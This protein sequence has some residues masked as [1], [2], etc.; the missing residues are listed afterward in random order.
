M[1]ENET[2][3]TTGFLAEAGTK[4]KNKGYFGS[5]EQAGLACWIVAER[6]DALE[7]KDSAKM[8]VEEIIGR[9][10]QTPTIAKVKIKE[11]LMA[12]HQKLK[13]ESKFEMLKASLVIVVTDYSQV[14]WA[15]AGN[16]RLYHFRE[17]KF[18]FRSK[19]QT[20]AQVMVDSGVLDEDEVNE[21][22]ERNNLIN[23]LGGITE[24]KPFVSEPFQLLDGDV[25]LLCNSGF[26]EKMKNNEIA[27]LLGHATTP[28]EFLP[29]LKAAILAKG[30]A[31]MKNYTVG[32]IFAQKV[33]TG[34]HQKN[35]PVNLKLPIELLTKWVAKITA[36]QIHPD[37]E[38]IKSDY[39]KSIAQTRQFFTGLLTQSTALVTVKQTDPDK[40][41]VKSDYRKSIAQ[42]RQFFTGLL[43]KSTALV[44]VKQTDP[45]KEVVKINCRKSI[46]SSRQFFTGL[47]TK[48]IALLTAKR[49]YLDKQVIKKICFLILLV[50]LSVSFGWLAN[51]RVTA[52]RIEQE[53][54]IK[55]QIELKQ[56]KT[57]TDHEQSGDQLAKNGQYQAAAREY[58][59]ALQ[60]A[61]LLKVPSK[62]AKLAKKA[63]AA[64]LI[65]A[66]DNYIT[67]GNFEA[68]LQEYAKA[69]SSVKGSDCLQKGL[70][71]KIDWAQQMMDLLRLDQAGDHEANR[72][73]YTAAQAIYQSAQSIA[74]RLSNRDFMVMLTAKLDEVDR[75]MKQSDPREAPVI[76]ASHRMGKLTKQKSSMA[77]ER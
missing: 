20:I 64:Q 6:V 34:N 37:M 74:S 19:D 40:E 62:M 76:A 17:G 12:A 14:V 8:A 5:V 24:S 38:A 57:L 22:E 21:R 50:L 11:Y 68:A 15:V 71:K 44:T 43:T 66:G 10:T 26:W 33:F 2:K 23:Y 52:M 54:V 28:Q 63:D 36:K 69:N 53:L 73:N 75:K 4:S 70:T 41:V 25:L 51:Q 49:I 42:S 30:N 7:G 29:K 59:L 9:F 77:V 47:L 1:E 58:Q 32:A 27:D 48:L 3:F 18:N 39:R 61:G 46:A 45:D 56:Q 72:R 13:D 16:V 55:K 60:M 35:I 31:K 67:A 65:V